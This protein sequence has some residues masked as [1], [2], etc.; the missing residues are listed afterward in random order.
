LHSTYNINC[1]R[2]CCSGRLARDRGPAPA[3][4]AAVPVRGE[5]IP[6]P[7]EPVGHDRGHEPRDQLDGLRAG[8]GRPRADI[9]LEQL[10]AVGAS[11]HVLR[12][13][14]VGQLPGVR[15]RVQVRQQNA[16]GLQHGRF[17]GAGPRQPAGD[18]RVRGPRPGRRQ[19]R[20]GPVVGI[21]VPDGARHHVQ[22]GAAA[23]AQPTGRIHRQRHPT[24]HHGHAGRFRCAV[25]HLRRLAGRLLPERR[26]RA[27]VDG[28]LAAAGR[29]VAVHTPVHQPG[30]EGLHPE[31][32][33]QHGR[34]RHTGDHIILNDYY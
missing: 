31:H 24:G 32:A 15:A 29:R 22:V 14:P 21:H 13:L 3:E 10:D 6:D 20:A 30:R 5:R 9:R 33:G 18:V 25:R 8:A 2:A 28:R 19:V 27:D 23:R 26:R 4:P 12:G 16:A 34:P 7:G 1:A 11:E 17:V